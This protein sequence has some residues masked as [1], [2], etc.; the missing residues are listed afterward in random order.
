MEKKEYGELLDRKQT[1]DVIFKRQ[2]QLSEQES[3]E[4]LEKAE[5]LL[6]A[7]I[8]CN[9]ILEF[10]KVFGIKREYDFIK[11]FRLDMP[12]NNMVNMSMLN[13]WHHCRRKFRIDGI[14]IVLS[15][16][17]DELEDNQ[18][19]YFCIQENEKQYVCGLDNV[20]LLT[21]RVRCIHPF[22][23]M[24]KSAIQNKNAKKNFLFVTI[25]ILLGLFP[26]I[27]IFDVKFF[28]WIT[29]NLTIFYS[30]EILGVLLFLFQMNT[31]YRYEKNFYS[32]FF[33]KELSFFTYLKNLFN[34]SHV[35][36][37]LLF[38]VPLMTY[39][40][41]LS[42][43]FSRLDHTIWI[44]YILLFIGFFYFSFVDGT[45][46][47]LIEYQNLKHNNYSCLFS[48]LV[49]T[50]FI[51]SSITISWIT[52]TFFPDIMISMW[53]FVNHF[54]YTGLLWDIMNAVVKIICILLYYIGLPMG[55]AMLLG[56]GTLFVL[57]STI[58]NKL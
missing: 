53:S 56:L 30:L 31:T 25:V 9:I 28:S 32:V 54:A 36:D 23:P 18:K 47:D 11:K 38:F 41:S 45:D 13:I 40:S 58:R 8:H 50:Y 48:S 22:M 51:I 3:K 29:S 24:P 43:Q 5:N 37:D 42:F 55:I 4:K 19:V 17:F 20:W 26:F 46:I 21:P 57:P 2:T 34:Y 6:K 49:I 7:V 1:D 35:L 27:R 10:A 15:T 12:S 16:S 52:Y 33:L 14:Q 44:Q 39:M